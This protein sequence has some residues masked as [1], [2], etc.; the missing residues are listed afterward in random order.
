VADV[1]QEFDCLDSFQLDNPPTSTSC[2]G[3]TVLPSGS[4]DS[5]DLYRIDIWDGNVSGKI[6]SEAG[7]S[8]S[9]TQA[10][11]TTST[12][13]FAPDPPASLDP[14]ASELQLLSAAPQTNQSVPSSTT[15][16][17][18]TP[19]YSTTNASWVFALGTHALAMYAWSLSSALSST[20]LCPANNA[21]CTESDVIVELKSIT[22][23]SND[24]V[25]YNVDYEGQPYGLHG[26]T[27]L[28]A[29]GGST[30]AAPPV[31]LSGGDGWVVGHPTCHNGVRHERPMR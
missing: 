30:L 21:N 16:T 8:V 3:P 31:P 15:V 13:G 12:I 5:K 14:G 4:T 19:S 11:G 2:S 6:N 22:T 10:S 24:N 1:Y 23:D 20:K 17:V 27:S 26:D 18:G 25:T 28:A 7:I 9:L 29:G